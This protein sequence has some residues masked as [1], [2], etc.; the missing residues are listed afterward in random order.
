[1][2]GRGREEEREGKE[3]V[4][5]K[6]REGGEKGREGSCGL[7]YRRTWPFLACLPSGRRRSA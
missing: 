4:G 6:E 1:L 7:N 3:G 2:E 5:K